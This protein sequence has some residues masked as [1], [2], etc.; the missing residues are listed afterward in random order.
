MKSFFVILLFIGIIWIIIGY[1]NQI[2]TCPPPQVEYRYIPRTFEEEQTSPAKVSQLFRD[3]FEKPSPWVAGFR[4]EYIKPNI[5]ELNKY[6]I[7]Q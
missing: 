3:M 4:I 7:Q 5:Y 1:I 6:Y 2:Q